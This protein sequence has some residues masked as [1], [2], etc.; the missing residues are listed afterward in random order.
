MPRSTSEGTTRGMTVFPSVN[1]VIS[2]GMGLH[3]AP[4][5]KVLL[6]RDSKAVSGFLSVPVPGAADQ[7]NGYFIRSAS[8]PMTVTTVT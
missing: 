2:G 7:R 1:P 8:L 5:V 4:D 3:S 6:S